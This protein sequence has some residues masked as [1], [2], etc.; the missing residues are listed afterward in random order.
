M[1]I[2]KITNAPT[3]NEQI[4]KINEIID[5]KLENTAT[6]SNGLTIG[7]TAS[8]AASATNIGFASTAGSV[9]TAVGYNTAANGLRT[10]SIG[11]NARIGAAVNDAI[12]IGSGTNPTA[13]T[14]CV[15]FHNSGN[16]P[17]LDGTTG[18]IPNDRLN[19][20]STPTQDSTNPVTSGGV[21]N[22]IHNSG[23]LPAGT[24]VANQFNLSN[25]DDWLG[26]NGSVIP[27]STTLY[28]L[29]SSDSTHN[30]EYYQRWDN[31]QIVNHDNTDTGLNRIPVFI[32]EEG[33]RVARLYHDKGVA[34]I[35]PSDELLTMVMS[36][37]TYDTSGNPTQFSYTAT[38]ET[39]VK[40]S[41]LSDAQFIIGTN[42]QYLGFAFGLKNTS[43]ATYIYA[44]D[45][46]TTNSWNSI[47]GETTGIVIQQDKK[48]YVKLVYS[49]TPSGS[50]TV[51]IYVSENID[52][53]SPQTY[54][55][56]ISNAAGEIPIMW[57]WKVPDGYIPYV[58][59]GNTT[60]SS[61]SIEGD[62]YLD[63]TSIRL[64]Y[65]RHSSGMS[66]MN[67]QDL[68]YT[69]RP[70]KIY[71]G[72]EASMQMIRHNGYCGSFFGH[73]FPY[74]TTLLKFIDTNN[75]NTELFVEADENG[76]YNGKT[77]Y[78][79][80]ELNTYEH[81]TVYVPVGTVIM[82]RLYTATSVNNNVPYAGY[83]YD[84]DDIESIE[85]KYC[86]NN[87]TNFERINTTEADTLIYTPVYDDVYLVGNRAG[88]LTNQSS[89]EA[90]L[91][92]IH[93]E[94]W[95]VGKTTPTGCVYGGGNAGD[96][97]DK[98]DG[99]GDGQSSWYA[100]SSSFN[101]SIYGNS[102]KVRPQSVVVK[103]YIK[104]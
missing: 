27:T 45:T 76:H 51:S 70:Y 4:D 31:Y 21:Y 33:Y 20:D 7:G 64:Q 39:A 12:Q 43:G 16:Y 68:D 28:T 103:Y 52:Y 97:Y 40:F 57:S 77:I 2:S 13:K 88:S 74:N 17:M 53:S 63:H 61:Q 50:D 59:F 6:G 75:S 9:G 62:L 47:N 3:P 82:T 42:R 60:Y 24:I 98:A 94:W 72:N 79:K 89:Y 37:T 48:Y 73:T 87:Y 11:Y 35:A 78:V 69:W 99:G 85:Y 38:I 23:T 101:S 104:T 83:Y 49:Y 93:G 14:L 81:P 46:R 55:K 91:P 67:F 71:Q 100:I 90:G 95:T 10:T 58:C 102:I 22:A 34:A 44:G 1:A 56:T 54:T 36:N 80:K 8:T 29:A 26:C 84:S 96:L 25:S 30:S 65:P 86:L 19:I 32:N 18:K 41:H 66:L 15:G 92:D 5:K